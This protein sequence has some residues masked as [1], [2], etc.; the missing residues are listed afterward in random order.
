VSDKKILE[1]IL[2]DCYLMNIEKKW[3]KSEKCGRE[4]LHYE[5]RSYEGKRVRITIEEIEG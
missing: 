1:G 3:P 4:L 5:F 2:E